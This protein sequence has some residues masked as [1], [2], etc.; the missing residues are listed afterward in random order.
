MAT[1]KIEIRKA[2]TGDMSAVLNLV[3]ALALYEK[4]PEEVRTTLE[5]YVEDFEEGIFDVI[6]AEQGSEIVGIVLYFITFS[7][8]KG[9]MMFL[10]DFVVKEDL[11][12]QGIGK[13]LFEALIEEAKYLGCKLMKWQVLDWNEPAINFYNKYGASYESEWWNV[14]ITI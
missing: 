3:K 8:W 7:T 1:M 5:E 14:R 11:R 12:G 2:T 10:E 4:A 9:R 13:V 6:V